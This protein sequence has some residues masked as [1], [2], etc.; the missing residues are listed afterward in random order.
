MGRARRHYRGRHA[1]G[2]RASPRFAIGAHVQC[3]YHGEWVCG[4]VLA[5]HYEEPA[6]VFHPYQVRLE[7]GQRI[8]A[9]ADT[10]ECI[11]AAFRF[12]VGADVLCN[13]G[14]LTHPTWAQGRVVAW[15]YE[16][17]PGCFHPYQVR[18]ECGQLIFAPEDTDALIRASKRKTGGDIGATLA[19]KDAVTV[20]AGDGDKS[21][22]PAAE[23]ETPSLAGG[24]SRG[25]YALMKNILAS[26][27]IFVA[28]R[29]AK[30][31]VIDLASDDADTDFK[32]QRSDPCGERETPRDSQRHP[33]QQDVCA[34]RASRGHWLQGRPGGLSRACGRT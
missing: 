21:P 16:E 22:P 29:S 13:I 10:D 11:Q 5:H 27:Q 12:R 25:H 33:G 17:P 9:P 15:H 20:T 31:E 32:C 8:Y 1:A 3:L 26:W 24:E 34:S 23:S 18:L 7:G 2:W 30:D 6:G 28:T 4:R 19:S 14:L